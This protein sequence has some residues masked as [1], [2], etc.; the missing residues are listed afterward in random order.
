MKM[1]ESINGE[2]DVDCS[3]YK[4]VTEDGLNLQHIKVQTPAICLAA[5]RQNPFAMNYIDKS[6]FSK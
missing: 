1:Q 2:E 5:I 4:A 6:I 3:E